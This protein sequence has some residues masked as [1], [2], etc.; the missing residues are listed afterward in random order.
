[1]R[2]RGEEDRVSRKEVLLQLAVDVL[3]LHEAVTLVE[4]THPFFDIAEVGT[5]LIIEEGLMALAAM[6]EA[7][8]DKAYLADLKIM[9][10][11]YLEASSAFRRGADIVTALAVADDRTIEEALRA[12]K[13]YD[14]EV[15]VDLINVLDPAGRAKHL[16]DMGVSILCVHTAFDRQSTEDPMR[17][18][19]QVRQA[20]SCR[21][22]VAGGLDGETTGQTLA[23][24]ADI[25]IVGGAVLKAKDR[26]EAARAIYSAIHGER[27]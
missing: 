2:G 15:M 16:E 12:S 18:L 17:E 9:D 19:A 6:K 14:G 13:E 10:A 7:R 3:T 8:P 1:V 4:E 25:V 11:G 20:V 22:A 21:V 24:G 5:P 27:R 26:R 23:L